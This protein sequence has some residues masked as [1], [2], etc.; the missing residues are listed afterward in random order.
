MIV[1]VGND[2]VDVRRFARMYARH[3]RRLLQRL[4]TEEERVLVP[5]SAL[6]FL[7][8]RWAAKE[9]VAKAVGHG[10]RFPLTLQRMSVLNDSAGRPFFV[11]DETAGRFLAE[12]GVRG[13][14]LSLSHDGDYAVATVVAE[15]GP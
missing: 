6:P 1:G 2:I 13:C 12:R 10:V 8:G 3:P 7:A 15:G 5:P 11:F 9:A 14:H 4:L